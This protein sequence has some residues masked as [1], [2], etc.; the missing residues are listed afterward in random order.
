MIEDIQ[1]LSVDRMKRIRPDRATVVVSIL[2]RSEAAHRPRLAGFRSVI[3][4]DFEDTCEA[5][6]LA[7]PGTWPDEPGEDEHSRLAQGP[8]E[9]VPSLQDA[10]KIVDFINTNQRS[11]ERLHL[12]VHCFGGV[13]RSAAVARWA[14]MKCMVPILGTISTDRANP[15]LLRLLDKAAQ[16]HDDQVIGIN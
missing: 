16:Q 3:E 8:G 15:R 6:K 7:E 14:S 4:L 2:D 12:V 1:F 11:T 10:K 5:T 9:R 13:S